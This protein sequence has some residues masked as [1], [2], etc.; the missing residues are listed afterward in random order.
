M[1]MSVTYEA[2]TKTFTCNVHG[3]I[4]LTGWLPC[5]TGCDDG[6]FDAYEEDPI[7]CDPGE[8]RIC[9]ECKGE[10]GFMMCGECAGNNPDVEW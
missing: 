4:Q 9:S 2:K 8:T 7:N 10:G 3:E 1:T 5:Y 6:T